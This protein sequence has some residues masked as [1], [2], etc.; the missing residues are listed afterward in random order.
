MDKVQ[1]SPRERM[2]YE[3]AQA[4]REDGRETRESVRGTGPD[5]QD[6]H[7]RVAADL[8]VG[9]NGNVRA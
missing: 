7:H 8:D 1:R 5:R 4:L 2:V 6:P 3:A 9:P